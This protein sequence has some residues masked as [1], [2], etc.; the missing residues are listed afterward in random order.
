[1]EGRRYIMGS[2]LNT[3]WN[4]LWGWLIDLFTLF[5]K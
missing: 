5:K 4:F 1:M 2:W 3:G